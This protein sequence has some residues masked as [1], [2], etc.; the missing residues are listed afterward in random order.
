MRGNLRKRDDRTKSVVDVVS[1][2]GLWEGGNS[3]LARAV[4]VGNR[5]DLPLVAKGC[6]DPID[7]SFRGRRQVRSADEEL[8]RPLVARGSLPDR[9]DAG[10]RAADDEALPPGRTGRAEGEG[11][12]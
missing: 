7:R 9:L 8:H 3:R 4:T 2:D 11:P 12:F 5:R 6:R 10:V 1:H